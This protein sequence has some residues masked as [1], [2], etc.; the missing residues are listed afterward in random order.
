MT[1]PRNSA[2]AGFSDTADNYAVSMAPSLAVIAGEVVR[3]AALQPRER[4][5]DLGTGTGSGA[6]AARGEGRSV[7]GLDAAPGMLDIARRE[8][9]GVTFVEADFNEVPFPDASFDALTAVHCLHFADDPVATL[10]EWLRVTVADGRLSISLPGPRAATYLPGFDRVY[11]RYAV[12]RRAQIPT[13]TAI[14]RW[15][16]AAGWRH[17]TTDAD[18]TTLIRLPDA[19]AF[20]RWMRTGSRSTA[21]RGWG[22]EQFAA[23][24]AEMLAA[25]PRELDGSLAIPFG[26]LYLAARR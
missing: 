11:R 15:A 4:V 10:A 18:P 17:V 6:S 16:R 9:P 13:R 1:A 23:F 14:T 5:L 26:T 2:V 22:E 19:A 7:T 24:E 20:G 25:T 8:V 12:R 3:R 21:T